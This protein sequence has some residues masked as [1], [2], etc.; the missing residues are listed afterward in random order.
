MLQVE[1]NLSESTGTERVIMV[2]LVVSLLI[3]AYSVTSMSSIAKSVKTLSDSVDSLSTDISEGFEK[4][5]EEIEPDEPEPREEVIL[6][7][8]RGGIII[9]FDP[10]ESYSVP[11]QECIVPVYETLLRYDPDK[12]GELMP[13]LAES[14]EISDNDYSYIFHIRRDV[15]FTDGSILDAYDVLF[16]YDR[17]ITLNEEEGFGPGWIIGQI[18]LDASSVIDAYTVNITLK[19]PFSPFIYAVASQW[20]AFIVD[21]GLVQ[22]HATAEDPWAH[23]Y[24]KENMVGTGPYMLEEWV[25]EDHVTLVKNPDYWGGWEGPHVDK[26]YMPIIT[27]SAIRRLRLE[28]GTLDIGGLDLEDALGIEGTEGV[29][30][31]V[32]PGLT[33]F[34]IFMNT[35][36]PP[37]DNILV[38]Q[39]MSYLYDYTGTIETIRQ[40]IGTQARGPIPQALWGWDPDCPQFT[41]NVTKAEEL[42]RQAGY[43]PEDIE[44]EFWFQGVESRRVAEVLQ[45]KAA[46]IG[47]KIN[48][49]ETTWAILCEAV[50][51]GSGDVNDAHHF[52]GLYWWPDYADPLGFLEVMYKGTVS[53]TNVDDYSFFNWGYYYNPELNAIL[54]EVVRETDYSKCVELYHQAQRIIVEDAPAIFVFDTLNILTYRDWVKGYYFNPLYTGTTDFYNIYIEGRE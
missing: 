42:I 2:L 52:A 6:N 11:T 23:E 40:G 28:E 31:E 18:D 32:V 54:D 30:V 19:H 43:E 33:N 47:V 51:P 34:M 37:L 21:K 41:M 22:E 36:K 8:P 14:W 48:L 4:L 1:T 45:A 3:S 46:E 9:T 25:R 13:C 12:P 10:H 50:R 17:A 38:R 53:S 49:H 44:L 20:G 27:E 24:L 29:N 7:Y 26:I 16:S 39:A 35:Q 15:T 5:G